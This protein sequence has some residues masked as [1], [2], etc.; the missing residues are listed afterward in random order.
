MTSTT[1]RPQ[2]SPLIWS[3]R[4]GLVAGLVGAGVWGVSWFLLQPTGTQDLAPYTIAV[5]EQTLQGSLVA[6]GVVE[7]IRQVN[8]SPYQAG[9]VDTINVDEGELVVEGQVLVLMDGRDLSIRV[10]EYQALLAKAEEELALREEELTRQQDLVTAGALSPLD[11]SQLVSR[12]RSQQSQVLASRQQLEELLF[13]QKELT[14]RAPI[15]GLVM[16]RFAEP[17]SYVAPSV[18]ASDSAGATRASLLALGSGRK[19]VASLPES[20]VGRIQAKQAANVV[21]S[22]FPDQP[23]AAQ[24]ETIA[25]RSQ[26]LQNVTTFDV[27]LKLLAEDPQIRYGMSGDVEFFTGELSATPVVPTVAISTSSGQTGVYVVDQNNQPVFRSVALGYSSGDR[28]QVLD[29]LEVGELIFIN[30]PP[31]AR[32]VP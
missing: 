11:L 10:Q 22:S 14:V 4:N 12:H 21:L 9:I 28:T 15:S 29:G 2:S 6:S 1:G 32:Q 16:E 5:E 30:L 27:T 18:A 31:W 8:L 20:D 23:L 25:P 19:V 24:V 26:T 13:L 7:P 17:G 3:W